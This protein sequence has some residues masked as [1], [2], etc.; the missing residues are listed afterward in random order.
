MS[1]ELKRFK[2]VSAR[3]DAIWCGKEVGVQGKAVLVLAAATEAEVKWFFSKI[4]WTAWCLVPVD[5]SPA[6]EKRPVGRP[7]QTVPA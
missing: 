1:Q 2:M 4:D 5:D 7:R 6:D 3:Q